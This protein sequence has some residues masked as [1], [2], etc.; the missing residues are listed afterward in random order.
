MQLSSLYF[1]NQSD[2][3]REIAIMRKAVAAAMLMGASGLGSIATAGEKV[4]IVHSYHENYAWVEAINVG[5]GEGLKG[6]RIE[7]DIAYMDTKR[8]QDEASMRK[9]GE[10]VRRKVER[11]Q[12]DVILVADD[13]A[14]EYFAKDYVGKEHPAIIFLGVN[15]EPERYGYPAANVTGILERP[16]YVQTLEYL[17]AV[18]PA[19]RTVAL[20]G[21]DSETATLI[22]DY[23]RNQV[24]PLKVIASG[25]A[26][27]FEEW[28]ALVRDYNE[29]ADA[30]L[31]A[32]YETVKKAP[33]DEGGTS[34]RVKPK[35]VAAWTVANFKK[36]TASVFEFGV[37]DGFL[38]GVVEDGVAH[39]RDAAAMALSILNGKEVKDIPIATLR[40][41]RRELNLST[42]Q[43]IGLEVP[44]EMLEKADRVFGQ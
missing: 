22:I 14:Q 17:R 13:N 36:P 41:G 35:E 26:G 31:V 18:A 2:T 9:A 3:D 19:V 34:V 25:Q 1:V 27:T 30:L 23:M 12:P 44:A 43:A 10:M 21:D 28:K 39:G 15:S 4:L 5:V 33:A 37:A 6:A 7:L 32:I 16:L 24:S 20:I 11:F 38:C 29:S 42:A 40:K 8:H